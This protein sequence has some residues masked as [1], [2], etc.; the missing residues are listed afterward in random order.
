MPLSHLKLN[1]VDPEVISH[2][3][4]ARVNDLQISVLKALRFG[5]ILLLY[6]CAFATI[7]LLI[8][9]N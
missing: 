9:G 4:I 7:R 8:V 3:P 1:I 5:N 6:I 2:D